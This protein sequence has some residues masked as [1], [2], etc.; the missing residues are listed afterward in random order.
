MTGASLAPAIRRGAL[1]AICVLAAAHALSFGHYVNDDAYI[2]YRYAANLAAG[3]GP[4]FNA[5]ERVEGYS[6]LLLVLLAGAAAVV[7]GPTAVPPFAK[8]L[9]V[10][11]ATACV[12]LAFAL[13]RALW[14][15]ERPGATTGGLLA[16]GLVAASPAFAVNAASGLETGL[17]AALIAGA[18]LAALRRPDSAASAALFALAA[19]TRPEAPALFAAAWL[20]RA[21]TRPD[22][23]RAGARRELLR[24]GALVTAVV[25]AHVAWRSWT[26]EGEW[27]PNTYYAKSGGGSAQG[28]WAYVAAGIGS[29]FF[30]PVGLV[31]ATLGL[32][33]GRS[34]PSRWV[35]LAATAALAATVPVWAATD[36][37]VGWR[38]VMP[39]V[40]L[41]AALAAAG[42][43]LG[44]GRLAGSLS[45]AP[46]LALL[47]LPLAW[48]AQA[49]LRQS[50]L[51]ETLVRAQ[52]Y[53]TGHRAL[54]RWLA[55]GAAVPGET[56]ALMDIGIVGFEA[57][58][59]RVLDISGL[60]DRH[61]AKSPGPFVNK[62]Y[63]PAYVFDRSPRHVVIV[64][65]APG[66]P[67]APPAGGIRFQPWTATEAR[68][69][70][71]P[72][73]RQRYQRRP[74]ARP[75]LRWPLDYAAAIGASRIFEH[76][77]PGQHYLLAVF[78]RQG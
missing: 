71:H 60:T 36:W 46:A 77:L 53:Q 54:G 14:P 73:F 4:Y 26:Y 8:A 2:T 42:W 78:T 20:S 44:V 64:L 45:W 61:V 43:T 67:W 37:M 15:A 56:V 66:S 51:A 65:T 57:R 25:L 52:G 55:A 23:N 30:G 35:P 18:L 59:V 28:A 33:A 11:A 21:L 16:A 48:H 7:G 62:F 6:N 40:P 41:V 70:A 50:M 22:A 12:P 17:F 13:A 31:L 5:G 74:E 58:A 3:I 10:V 38:L 39:A 69:L 75:D 19:L 27:L 72:S 76:A 47:A 29:P 63:D 32:W 49:P 68:L 1:L 24:D 9:G 34:N